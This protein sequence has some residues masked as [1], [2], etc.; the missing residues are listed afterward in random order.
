MRTKTDNLHGE[1]SRNECPV[2]LSVSE[3]F[4]SLEK[5]ISV[6]RKERMTALVA[7]HLLGATAPRGT[8]SD[9][10]S[11]NEAASNEIRGGGSEAAP[12]R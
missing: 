10:D 2:W 6:R 8:P 12:R 3:R 1:R 9:A 7:G 5:R 11:G 4:A